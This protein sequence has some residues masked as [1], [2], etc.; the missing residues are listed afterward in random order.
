MIDPTYTLYKETL[1]SIDYQTFTFA[2]KK[3]VI[4]NVLYTSSRLISF[5]EGFDKHQF[6][7]YLLK[8]MQ[9]SATDFIFFPHNPTSQP[10][11]IAINLKRKLKTL[12]QI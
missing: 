4:I 5:T 6:L 12:I 11:K 9:K 1:I 8:I 10:Y 7:N 2:K 3:L